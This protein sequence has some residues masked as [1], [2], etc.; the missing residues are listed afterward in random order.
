MD[1]NILNIKLSQYNNGLNTNIWSSVHEKATMRLS[2]KKAL[3][4]YTFLN[5]NYPVDRFN[6]KNF[7]ELF[8]QKLKDC[9][10]MDRKKKK[11][12]RE[13]KHPDKTN[14]KTLESRCGRKFP[15]SDRSSHPE[16]FCE[17]L[18]LEISQNS[19]ENTCA[20]VSFVIKLQASGL[21]LY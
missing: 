9:F 2:W 16:M 20:R 7:L 19:K 13:N 3:L 18:F 17:K 6:V 8:E 1:T 12:F 14:I 15:A 4:I 5:K 10:L 11:L 21:H